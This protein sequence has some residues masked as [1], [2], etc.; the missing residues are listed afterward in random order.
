[1]EA[2][3]KL[4]ALAWDSAPPYAAKI[5]PSDGSAL[6]RAGDT[7]APAGAAKAPIK[8]SITAPS[9]ARCTTGIRF[10]L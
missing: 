2:A 7:A 9:T 3:L 8:A 6:N 10:I 1:M 5:A 4:A